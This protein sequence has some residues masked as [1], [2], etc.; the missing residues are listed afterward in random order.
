MTH[1]LHREPPDADW[2]ELVRRG[3]VAGFE[4][5]FRAHYEPLCRFAMG[6]GVPREAAE[7]LMQDVFVRIWEQRAQWALQ[8]TL[9]AY[10]YGAARNRALDYAR[11]QL[12]VRQWEARVART[13][14]RALVG[15]ICARTEGADERLELRELDAAIQRAVAQLPERCRQTFLLSRVHGL[16]YA[17]IAATMEVSVKT[18]KIQMGRALKA[19]RAALAPL[20]GAEVPAEH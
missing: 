16:G 5:M 19:L 15:T 17:D 14:G 10:L 11:H 7:D 1:P 8:T 9:A 3:D 18:V 2:Y 12:V 20:A 4:A 6:Y 13:G